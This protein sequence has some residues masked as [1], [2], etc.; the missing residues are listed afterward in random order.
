[1]VT[2]Y[3]R[4]PRFE[5]LAPGTMD[6][7]LSLLQKYKEKAKVI[8]GGTD[9][10]PKLKRR[11]IDLPEYIIDLKKIPELAYINYDENNGLS[12]GPLTTLRDLE[13]SAVVRDKFPVLFQAVA[14]I[15][16]IQVRNRGTLGGNI[17]NAVPSADTAPALLTLEAKL[18][19]VCRQGERIVNI[20][21]FFAGPNKTVC[22]TEEVLREIQVPNLP[23]GGKGVYVKLTP[24]KAMDL[25]VVGVAV[26]MALESGVCKD[27]RI[28]LG[29]VA[30][31]PLRITKAE[32]VLKGKRPE[33]EVIDKA[34][35]IA[36]EESHPIDDH[37]ASAEYRREMVMI[38]TRRAIREVIS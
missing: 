23:Q 25:A 29:A 16:S 26:V 14:S 6:E 34:S 19:L 32:T 7:T 8:A 35:Q 1:M 38:I 33:N 37:R 22:T 20:E 27:I 4:L 12:I 24:R 15:G 28:A 11:Q 10:I 30:P 9:V 5:Y 36:A 17:C 18:K 31:T 2:F 3:R 13:K 21:D